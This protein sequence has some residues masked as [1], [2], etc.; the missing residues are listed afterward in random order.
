MKSVKVST[1]INGFNKCKGGFLCSQ[2]SNRYLAYEH[3]LVFIKENI[4]CLILEDVLFTQA[5]QKDFSSIILCTLC[6][7]NWWY[8]WG[9]IRSLCRIRKVCSINFE[10]PKNDLCSACHVYPLSCGARII[11]I[12]FILNRVT[13]GWNYLTNKLKP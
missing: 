2:R 6:F 1:V 3:C 10:P 13:W 9:V 4:Y 5:M 8:S 11:S 12:L 7:M